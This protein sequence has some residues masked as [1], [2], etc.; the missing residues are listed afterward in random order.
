M[1]SE[2]GFPVLG[3]FVEHKKGDDCEHCAD[4]RQATGPDA[5]DHIRK[6]YVDWCITGV[7]G[8]DR[9]VGTYAAIPSENRDKKTMKDHARQC[10]VIARSS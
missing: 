8:I 7:T 10:M 3:D 9:E 6:Y 5:E 4:G 1:W 2:H